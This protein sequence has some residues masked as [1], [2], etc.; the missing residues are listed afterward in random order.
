MLNDDTL[1]PCLSPLT[2]CL[3][4]LTPC[5]APPCCRTPLPTG[6]ALQPQRQPR[7]LSHGRA[8]PPG[9]RAEHASRVG[10]RAGSTTVR[11]TL[12][13]VSCAGLGN[14]VGRYKG[15][16]GIPSGRADPLNAGSP[17]YVHVA[18][19]WT[20][21]LHCLAERLVTRQAP[22]PAACRVCVIALQGTRHIRGV[23]G[24]FFCQRLPSHCSDPPYR[25]C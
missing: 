18:G 25:P 21:Q 12:R 24:R 22:L 5:L 13:L 4:S 2:P 20:L 14:S 15:V 17:L 6:A 10:K 8:Q 7:P 23:R 19:D 9:L 3:S 16:T 1:T 11:A